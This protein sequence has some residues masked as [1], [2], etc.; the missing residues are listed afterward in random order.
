V[1]QLGA[2]SG[3]LQGCA[4][5]ADRP[6]RHTEAAVTARYRPTSCQSAASA[7]RASE[8]RVTRSALLLACG[9]QWVSKE[10]YWLVQRMVAKNLRLLRNIVPIQG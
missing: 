10:R 8:N 5:A 1:R 2:C 4:A 9:A 6:A 7:V 3:Y